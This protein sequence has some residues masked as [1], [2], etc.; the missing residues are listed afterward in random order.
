MLYQLKVMMFQKVGVV[1]ELLA[2]M[3]LLCM[4]LWPQQVDSIDQLRLDVVL[5]MIRSPHFN[6]KM[7]ALKEVNCGKSSVR[8]MTEKSVKWDG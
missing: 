6:A 8:Y 5:G 1:C 4:A 3:K 2:S 7:N